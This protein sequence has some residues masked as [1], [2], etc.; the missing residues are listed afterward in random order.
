M[1]ISEDKNPDICRYFDRENRLAPNSEHLPKGQGGPPENFEQS[2]GQISPDSVSQKELQ[3]ESEERFSRYLQDRSQFPAPMDEEAYYGIAGK[4]VNIM[5]DHCES[6]RES[7]LFQ[8]LVAAGNIIGKSVCIYAGGSHLYPNEYAICV[9]DTSRG[10]KGTAWRINEHLFKNVAPE[11]VDDCV[12][13]DIQSGEGIVYS[14]RDE[15]ED[16]PKTDRRRKTS[17]KPQPEIAR[18]S[19][20]SDKRKLCF[21]EEISSTLKM[22]KRQGNTL[23]ETYRKAWDS[24]SKLQTLNKNSPLTASDPHISLIGHSNKDEILATFDKIL[25]SNGFAN[26]ILWCA[27]KRTKLLPNAE[28]L[29][30]NSHPDVIAALKEV[31]RQRF[32]NTDE[33]FRF[34]KT[35]AANAFWEKIYYKLNNQ[36]HV[37]F[38]DGVLVRDTSHLLKLAMIYAVLDK[39]DKIDNNHLQAALAMCDYSQ[40]SARWLF[41]EHTGNPLANNI[42]RALLREPAGL[43]RTQISDQVCYRNTPSS[44]LDE[45]LEALAKNGLAR[46]TIQL[47]EK[48]LKIEQWSASRIAKPS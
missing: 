13:S 16:P 3:R 1:S 24:P 23:T 6:S 42:Y 46:L 7:L 15:I 8:F 38:L 39:T 28:Y 30:W 17:Q 10:R 25:I 32:A 22:A 20:V 4:I 34:Y 5:T 18:D 12:I 33:P 36:K 44:K 2:N 29:N 35:P 9:G 14:I 26:R 43:S 21:E 37:S 40:T 47:G 45:A 48:G 27:S 11:W 41:A 19:G 31:F